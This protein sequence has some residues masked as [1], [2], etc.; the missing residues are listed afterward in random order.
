M[1]EELVRQNAPLLFPQ[2][3][4]NLL[5]TYEH[6]EAILH[7]QG[8][9]QEA[10]R[11][12]LLTMQKGSVLKEELAK[13]KQRLAD[14][15]RRKDAAE[16]ARIEEERLMIQAAEAEARIRE[17]E[18]R[19]AGQEAQDAAKKTTPQETTQPLALRYTVRRGETLPQIAAR[20]EIYNDSSLWPLIYRANRDQ[21]RDPKQLWPGQILKIPRQFSRDEAIEAKRYS[22]KK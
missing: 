11:L 6:G 4:H 5:E 2:E 17:Q 9:Q 20:S 12:Y 14:E 7:V 1:M 22:G 15:Q 10:D 18:K 8:D 3:Y 16:A 19:A 21:I 13:R